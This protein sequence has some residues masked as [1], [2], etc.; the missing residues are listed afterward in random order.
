LIIAY[1]C[2]GNLTH[3]L[4]RM[5]TR[6][7]LFIIGY[8][9]SLHEPEFPH[10]QDFVD[11]DWDAATRKKIIAY[12]KNAPFLP[13]VVTEESWCRFNCGKIANGSREH[14][15]GKYVW[16]EGLAHYLEMHQVRLPDVIV[17]DMLHAKPLKNDFN[18]AHTRFNFD[19]WIALKKS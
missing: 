9:H 18:P 16:P 17:N 10:P 12:L 4:A 2:C 15:D 11:A 3:P 1:Y 13:K 14:T 7:E 6:K 19:W 8:W 5:S